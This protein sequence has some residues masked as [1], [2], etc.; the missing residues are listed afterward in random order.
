MSENIVGRDGIQ[1]YRFSECSRKSYLSTFSAGHALCLSN[2]PNMFEVGYT[3]SY[4]IYF[5]Y[6][7]DSHVVALKAPPFSQEFIA[8]P[9]LR[10]F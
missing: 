4:G 3:F 9:L 7:H 8:F 5:L 2:K 6:W 10:Y 1:P